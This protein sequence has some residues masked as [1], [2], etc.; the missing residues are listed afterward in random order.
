M[1]WYFIPLIF[2]YVPPTITLQRY[3]FIARGLHLWCLLFVLLLD[4]NQFSLSTTSHF[5]LKGVFKSID[6][7]HF[8]TKIFDGLKSFT[9]NSIYIWAHCMT[10]L[11]DGRKI[12]FSKQTPS[13]DFKTFLKKYSEEFDL[14]TQL[15]NQSISPS[16]SIKILLF[17]IRVCPN[18]ILFEWKFN[19]EIS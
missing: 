11:R 5:D 16:I 15:H 4:F 7:I 17:Y 3:F 12:N 6:W 13:K 14:K 2:W 1:L 19:F 18:K 9:V 10:S 8:N